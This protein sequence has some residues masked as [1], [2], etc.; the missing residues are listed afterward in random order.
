MRI[1]IILI[2]SELSNMHQLREIGV[3]IVFDKGDTFGSLLVNGHEQK[4]F[5]AGSRHFK[6]PVFRQTFTFNLSDIHEAMEAFYE[7]NT[8]I[9]IYVAGN[10]EPVRKIPINLHGK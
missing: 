4:A 7:S 1:E 9:A 2:A 10:E 6:E 3:G 5:G 8:S